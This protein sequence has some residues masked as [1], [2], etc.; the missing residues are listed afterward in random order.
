MLLA[1]FTMPFASGIIEPRNMR[2][3]IFDNRNIDCDMYSVAN[4]SI[5]QV[6]KQLISFCEVSGNVLAELFEEGQ[7]LTE[8]LNTI[9]DKIS[10]LENKCKE[11]DAEKQT[12]GEGFG[13]SRRQAYNQVCDRSLFFNSKKPVDI[14]LMVAET[15]TQN[16][17]NTRIKYVKQIVA[18]HLYDVVRDDGRV[19]MKLYSDPDMFYIAWKDAVEIKVQESRVKNQM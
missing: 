16:L 4:F 5:I 17:Q 7:K 8:R 9:T 13:M 6:M 18:L 19:S 15:R 10:N 1:K 3:N 11:L 2:R 14:K 12:V